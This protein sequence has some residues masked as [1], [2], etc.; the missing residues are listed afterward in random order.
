MHVRPA[1]KKISNF[2]FKLGGKIIEYCAK[3]KYLGTH[4][5]EYLNFNQM[6]SQ[7]QDSASRALGAIICEMKKCGGFP[8]NTF[9]L[10]V[11]SCVF[12]I[13]DYCMEVFGYDSHAA[14]N[15]IHLRALRAFLGV[16]KTAPSHGVKAEMRWLEPR[17]RAHVRM[18]RF[19]LHVRSLPDSRLTKQVF[20]QD[21]HTLQFCTVDCWSTEVYNIL[22]N[23]GLGH[24]ITN[25]GNTRDI[26][27]TLSDNLLK[28]DTS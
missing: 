13:T 11:E 27:K 8:V 4:L 20:L 24:Y 23:N 22:N 25:M 15:A 18:I 1:K 9:K 16:K 2:K 19:F 3:Y 14:A 10:L 21:Q 12:S 26:L 6:S 28:N 17:S 5:N 7:M